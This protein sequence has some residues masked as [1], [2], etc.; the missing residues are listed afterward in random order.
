MQ[1]YD[2]FLENEKNKHFFMLKSNYILQNQK[3]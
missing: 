2:F 1:I 3:K